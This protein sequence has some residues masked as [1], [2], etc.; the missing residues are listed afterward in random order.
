MTICHDDLLAELCEDP[1]ESSFATFVPHG[2]N[3]ST[4]KLVF[5]ATS[6]AHHSLRVSREGNESVGFEQ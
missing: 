4:K 6:N 3:F 5:F 2:L 1:G